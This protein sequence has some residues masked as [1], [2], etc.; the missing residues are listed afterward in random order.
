MQ[1]SPQGIVWGYPKHNLAYPLV[2]ALHLINLYLIGLDDLFTEHFW[3][4]LLRQRQCFVHIDHDLAASLRDGI[5]DDTTLL[6]AVGS[7]DRAA[8]GVGNATNAI[9][10]VLG[11][12]AAKIR[13]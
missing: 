3:F 10:E 8:E 5:I 11:R 4:L 12:G 7:R 13:L 1:V 9:G 2:I 6:D